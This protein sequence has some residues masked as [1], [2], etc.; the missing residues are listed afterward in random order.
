MS[1]HAQAEGI[2][3]LVMLGFFAYLL[4][5]RPDRSGMPTDTTEP[6]T[7]H[8][9]EAT[10]Q[11]ALFWAL[12]QAKPEGRHETP[13]FK[14]WEG[15]HPDCT[16]EINGQVIYDPDERVVTYL[17]ASRYG[18]DIWKPICTVDAALNPNRPLDGAG[19]ELCWVGVFGTG[20]KSGFYK[21]GT[22]ADF[23]AKWDVAKVIPP[24]AP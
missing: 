11:L 6:N 15:D 3:I 21:D 20:V 5:P 10:R 14:L 1:G 17:G 12:V 23:G 19:V 8:C 4:W 9:A 13:R 22:F 16:I 2:A 24:V 7:W 18:R